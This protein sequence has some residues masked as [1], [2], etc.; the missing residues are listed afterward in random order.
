MPLGLGF[1]TCK[2]GM[3]ITLICMVAVR[4]LADKCTSNTYPISIPEG[5]REETVAASF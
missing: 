1:L 3:I 5:K 4:L 2:V